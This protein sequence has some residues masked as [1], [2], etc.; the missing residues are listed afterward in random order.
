MKSPFNEKNQL[1]VTFKY[2]ELIRKQIAPQKSKDIIY[3]ISC[4]KY[5][6]TYYVREEPFKPLTRML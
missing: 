1:P 2:I 4:E 5:Q 3:F 6:T